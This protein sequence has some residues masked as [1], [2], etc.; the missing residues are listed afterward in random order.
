MTDGPFIESHE[1]IA[2]FDILECDSLDEAIEVASRHP[3]AAG[4]V[5]ELRPA[6]PLDL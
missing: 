4:G 6:W 5:I 3:M 1:W 2:G